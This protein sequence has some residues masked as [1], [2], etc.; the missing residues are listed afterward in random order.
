VIGRCGCTAT[1]WIRSREGPRWARAG[2]S[3]LLDLNPATLRTVNLGEEFSAKIVNMIQ[4]RR[5]GTIAPVEIIAA[6]R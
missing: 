4:A 3:V 5:R 6:V 2:T 1:G